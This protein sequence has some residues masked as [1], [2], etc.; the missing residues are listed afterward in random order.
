MSKE[1][2]VFSESFSPT[3]SRNIRVKESIFSKKTL[4]QEVDVVNTYD[5]G[6]TLFL[7]GFFQT[8]ER[9]EFFYHESL[10]HPPMI[11]HSCPESVLIIGGGDGG[12]LEEVAKYK[13][14]KSITMVELD[15][16]VVE[17]SRRHL[18]RICGDAFEDERLNLNIGDGRQFMEETKETFDVI[19]LDLTDPLEP[20]KYVYTKEFYEM[21]RDHLNENGVLALHNESPFH[22]PNAFNVISKTLDSSFP[23]KRQYLTYMVGYMMDFAFAL[24]SRE[25]FPLLSFEELKR[26]L[27]EREIGDL[28]FYS[29]EMHDRLFILPGYVRNI[30]NTQCDISTDAAPYTLE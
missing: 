12:T 15:G 22:Y 6:L 16:E 5:Y 28:Q 7:G 9:D 17:I 25:P 10:V 4:Y 30:L 21:C 18:R 11:T 1:V 27:K 13:S 14:V 24:C 26:R 8:S 29:S 23:Y 3:M 19:I 2:R 20:S